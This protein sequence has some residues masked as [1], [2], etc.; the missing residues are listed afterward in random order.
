MKNWI[1]FVVVAHNYRCRSHE[2]WEWLKNYMLEKL[3]VG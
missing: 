2:H 3:R 1:E